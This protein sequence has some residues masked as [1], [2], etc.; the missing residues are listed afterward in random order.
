MSAADYG[1]AVHAGVA[2]SGLAVELTW[3]ERGPGPLMSNGA[4]AIRADEKRAIIDFMLTFVLARLSSDLH[5]GRAGGTR[6]VRCA[7]ATTSE[8]AGFHVLQ[9]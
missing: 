8:F 9:L 6:P 1:L 3:I 4:A 5:D 7:L 2:I